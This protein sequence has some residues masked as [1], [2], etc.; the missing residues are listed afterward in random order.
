MRFAQT[1][2]GDS[3]TISAARLGWRL[4]AAGPLLLVWDLFWDLVCDLVRDLVGDEK[5]I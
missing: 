4:D 5:I 3:Q 2:C 1:L